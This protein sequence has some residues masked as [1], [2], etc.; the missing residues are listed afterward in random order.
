MAAA[1]FAASPKAHIN[2][3]SWSQ[4][5]DGTVTISASRSCTTSRT[6]AAFLPTSQ[7]DSKHHLPSGADADET[8]ARAHEPLHLYAPPA[9][10]N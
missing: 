7:G 10:R 9:K 5:G 8:G 6:E 4:L 3:N 2:E 1:T